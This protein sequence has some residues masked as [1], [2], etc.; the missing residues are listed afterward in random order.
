MASQMDP[1][2]IAARLALR[3]GVRNLWNQTPELST[4]TIGRK[5]GISKNAVIGIAHRMHLPRRESPIKRRDPADVLK[6]R[7]PKVPRAP[8]VTL[9]KLVASEPKLSKLSENPETCRKLPELP[10]MAQFKP[11][12]KPV[13]VAPPQA[14]APVLFRRAAA[15]CFPLGDPARPG[16]RMCEDPTVPGKSYCLAHCRIAYYQFREPGQMADA[17]D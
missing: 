5:L 8:R 17:A 4:I 9:P 11:P 15:C 2:Y 1:E 3:D 7:K 6:E 16:F 14:P 13:H 12:P 10:P